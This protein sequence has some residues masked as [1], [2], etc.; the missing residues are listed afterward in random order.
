MAL[1][2]E[3]ASNNPNS[4]I[5]M[6]LL[7]NCLHPRPIDLSAIRTKGSLAGIAPTIFTPS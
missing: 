5:A 1:A 2:I 3:I 7:V 6:V 4:A